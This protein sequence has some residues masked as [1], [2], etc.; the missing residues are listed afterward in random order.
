MMIIKK[1]R[2]RQERLYWHGG[3]AVPILDSFLRRRY[4]KKAITSQGSYIG[5]P[6]SFAS[7]PIFPH[8][9]CGIFVS[10]S[11]RIGE[12]CIIFHQVTIGSNFLP[13]SSKNGAP[14]IGNNVYIG[15]GAKIIG[16]V[17]IGNNCRIGANAV[18]VKDIPDNCTVV[19]GE[20]RVI[21]SERVENHYY[22]KNAEGK[23]LE[24]HG[25]YSIEADVDMQEKNWEDCKWVVH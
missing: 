11:A 17:H 22:S 1:L 8:G 4:L 15:A 21:L 9:I 16:A 5:D 20:T 24:I 12:E 19:C 18:V 25:D 3:G 10:G 23:W 13:G 6:A 14:I 7:K 2:E